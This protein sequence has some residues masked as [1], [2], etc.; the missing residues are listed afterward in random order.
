GPEGA[1]TVAGDF[2]GLLVWGGTSLG[3][4]GPFVLGVGAEGEVRWLKQPECGAQASEG[5]AAAVDGAG[6]VMVACGDVLTRY[7]ADGTQQGERKLPVEGCASGEC[8][9]AVTGL[10]MVP[11]RGLAV[12]GWQRDGGGDG[13]N[14]DAFLRVVTPE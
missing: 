10:A 4:Q 12:A 13:W 9:L 6:A 1:V 7:A 8:S 3:T 2:T 11:G 14:Q 5:V